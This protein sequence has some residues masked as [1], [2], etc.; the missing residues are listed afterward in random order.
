VINLEPS[1][2][3]L[4]GIVAEHICQSNIPTEI[5]AELGRVIFQMANIAHHARVHQSLRRYQ[6]G[7]AIKGEL[8]TWALESLAID[9]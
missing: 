9:D 1:W 8:P 3:E 4:G 7:E 5:K 6:D 2:Q